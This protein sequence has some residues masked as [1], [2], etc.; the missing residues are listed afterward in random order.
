MTVPPSEND[1]SITLKV[2]FGR[3]DYVT[4]S[5]TDGVYDRAYGY[6]YNDVERV[7]APRIGR[8]EVL[9]ANHH[10]S[11]NSTNQLYVNTLDPDVSLIS[12]G[13]NTYGHPDQDTLDR[14]LATSRVYLT[15][16]GNPNRN[17]GSAT[18]VNNDIVITSSNGV[19]YTVD[20]NAYVASDPPTQRTLKQQI[21]DK[22]ALLEREL[23]A[24]RALAQQLPE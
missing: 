18:I 8:V 22:I 19:D 16:R 11:E 5:D 17:Y 20:G 13:D 1:Y 21:L 10:G 24:L 4:G 6:T 7:I 9:H 2:S 23:A 12:C 3:L 14:M 15:E